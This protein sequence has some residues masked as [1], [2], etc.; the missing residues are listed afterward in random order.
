MPPCFPRAE[1]AKRRSEAITA[2]RQ[3]EDNP[4]VRAVEALSR[5]CTARTIRTAGLRKAPSQTLERVRSRPIWSRFHARAI[6]PPALSLAIVGDDRPD[7]RDRRVPR[8]ELD[9][10][11]GAPA[12]RRADAAGTG[13]RGGR[14]ET[15]IAMPGKAQ[16]DIAY[17]FVTIAGSI[18]ATTRTG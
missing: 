11:S 6:R 14:R 17:G 10:W 7:A 8:L 16:T 18:R 13:V 3:D 12:G 5:C 9:G 4:A 2:I 15:R 1:I